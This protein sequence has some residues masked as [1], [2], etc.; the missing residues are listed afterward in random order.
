MDAPVQC[1]QDH[2]VH[3]KNGAILTRKWFANAGGPRAGAVFK[4]LSK[5]DG[6]SGVLDD[7]FKAPRGQG[8]NG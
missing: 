5:V 7:P 8:V 1:L 4:I 2:H 6:G 3:V